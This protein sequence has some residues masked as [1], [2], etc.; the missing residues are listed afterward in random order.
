M[1]RLLLL[2][3]L[4]FTGSGCTRQFYRNNV[5]REVDGLLRQKDVF[6]FWKIENYHVYPDPNARFADPAKPD[7]PPMPPDDPAAKLL[8]PNPQ[9]PGHAG[10]GSWEGTGYLDLLRYWDA[11]NRAVLPITVDANL[12]SVKQVQYLD[13][14]KKND[15]GENPFLLTMD[16]SIEL[17]LVNSREFQSRR[18]QLYL[19][20]LPVTLERFSFA[21]QFYDAH[22]GI[23]ER[24]GAQL[25]PGQGYRWRLNSDA[26]V[27]KLL[28]SGAL[29]L[30]SFANR[31]V[32]NLS[33]TMAN[34]TISVS[35]VNFDAIQPL[36]QGGGKAVTLEPL[37]QTERNL[38]YDIRQ[39][40]R[41]RKEFYQYISGGGDFGP[42]LS[43]I[44]GFG[45]NIGAGQVS[46]GS[47]NPAGPQITPSASGRINLSTGIAAPSEGYLTTILRR[48]LLAVE[49]ANVTRLEKILKLFEAYEEGGRVPSLQVG[50]V[51]LQLLQSQSNLLQADQ[52]M[53]DSLDRFKLQLGVPLTVP[54]ELD[55]DYI[56]PI[57]LQY[58]AYEE[59]LE[60]FEQALAAL[61][62][63][64]DI[65]EFAQIRARLRSL[66][67]DS[68]LV[69]GAPRFQKTIPTRFAAW[70]TSVLD[71]K[72]VRDKLFSLRQ[73]RN[74]LLELRDKQEEEGKTLSPQES[75]RLQEI[76]SDLP[77]GELEQAVRRYESGPWQGAPTEK[78]K[79]DVQQAAFREVR[80]TAAEV[81][82][83]AS[84][85]RFSRI[86]SSWTKLPPVH[87][88]GV[89]LLESDL[90]PAYEIAVK[91]AYENRLD[92]MN[93]RAQVVDSW[94]QLAVFANSLLGVFNVGYHVDSSTP[95]GRGTP[96][97]FEQE[98][99]RHQ[100]F[101]NAELPLVRVAERNSYRASL[102]AYQRA[103][104]NLMSTED[105]IAN[106]VR[107]D[108]RQL[109]VLAKNYK[110]QQQAVELAYQQV[111]SSLETFR[112]PQPPGGDGNNAASAAALTQQLLQAYARLPQT[113][114][115]LLTLW[116][117]YQVL[118]QQLYLD[119]EMMPLDSRGVW[120]DEYRART[121]PQ[122][123]VPPVVK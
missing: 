44:G 13:E 114:S 7:R 50:Q 70:T 30:A 67:T 86:R 9:K 58:Q 105:Q 47:G 78:I 83:E 100:L 42:S 90:E 92:L 2:L 51:Q 33:G 115:Q 35:T 6:P 29:L 36:L 95:P 91:T 109:Q 14:P 87:V 22:Q 18:E 37:T 4:I 97:L 121:I 3:A 106:Q 28:P 61:E 72:G 66:M 93:T 111:E 103:R 5:D 32:I 15:S 23:Y 56:R 64:D 69:R 94:R 118:R 112:A 20:A 34:K 99:T 52:N 25:P 76:L 81:L 89:D 24:T 57:F 74:K 119:I 8:A 62:R 1:V 39:Y 110:I 122:I 11:S 80:A 12:P 27:S 21:A 38:L 19:S 79:R 73:E 43:L 101:L 68:P 60:Q 16:Q 88:N 48:A 45:A 55:G 41:Y 53:R 84:N 120:I 108:I 98:R 75:A 82:G 46:L 10:E 85:E 116:I 49:R 113:Q 117:N 31:T 65:A 77:L 102:I 54:L 59:L 40:A 104:R 123:P 63:F 17:G 96:L 107:T 71:D 26:G